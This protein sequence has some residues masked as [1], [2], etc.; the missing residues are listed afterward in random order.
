MKALRN[1]CVHD[2]IITLNRNDDVPIYCIVN[3]Q[4][5]LKLV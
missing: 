4:G 3:D 2:K 1:I 5:T